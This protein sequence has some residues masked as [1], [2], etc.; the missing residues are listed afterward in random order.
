MVV[1]NLSDHQKTRLVIGFCRCFQH[2]RIF[3][4]HLGFVE[5]DAML[6]LVRGAFGW[7]VLGLVR[8]ELLVRPPSTDGRRRWPR[9]S[10]PVS[11]KRRAGLSKVFSVFLRARIQTATRSPTSE[12]GSRPRRGIR[13]CMKLSSGGTAIQAARH[14][15]IFVQS[16]SARRGRQPSQ[17]CET[18]SASPS[19]SR[20]GFRPR[21][22]PTATVPHAAREGLR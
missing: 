19:C 16:D 13:S 21:L 17:S 10:T 5:V 2:P 9:T 11:L 20:A 22:S 8:V 3:P 1:A 7:I 6:G 4:K 12:A 18:L 14:T 15:A